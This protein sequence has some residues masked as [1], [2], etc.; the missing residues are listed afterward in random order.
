MPHY[1]HFIILILICAANNT[2]QIS[3]TNDIVL[4]MLNKDKQK[5]A[6]NSETKAN[7]LKTFTIITDTN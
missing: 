4:Y 5:A 1:N 2:T 3:K 7:C 6:F